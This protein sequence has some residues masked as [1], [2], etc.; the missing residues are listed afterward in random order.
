MILIV[1]YSGI[2]TAIAR[3][4]IAVIKHHDQKQ[5]GEERVYFSLHSPALNE[6]RAEIHTGQ[7]PVAGDPE[8]AWRSAAYWIVLAHSCFVMPP[9]I[10][11]Q[12]Y[13]AQACPEAI[14]V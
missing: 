1:K 13:T 10:G 11:K 5:L 8:R 7:G 6:V 3:V 4:S 9:M 14:L 12:E 2:K